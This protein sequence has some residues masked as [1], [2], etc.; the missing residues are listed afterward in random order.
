VSELNRFKDELV[1][2]PELDEA[3]AYLIGN[4][5]IGLQTSAAVAGT[6]ARLAALGFPHTA[7]DEYPVR[8]REVT[9]SDLQRVAE[10]YF[11]PERMACGVVR[12]MNP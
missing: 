6:F 5:Q 12:G 1:P 11:A 7:L 3:K 2:D 4:F 10:T 9:S 8:L